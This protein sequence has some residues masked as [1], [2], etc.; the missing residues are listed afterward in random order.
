MRRT[1]VVGAVVSIF[2]LITPTILSTQ[3]NTFEKISGDT[4]NLISKDSGERWFGLLAINF[5]SAEGIP[6][7]Y[8]HG[9]LTNVDATFSEKTML[10]SAHILFPVITRSVLV[11]TSNDLNV[12]IDFFYGRIVYHG[13]MG[14]LLGFSLGISWMEV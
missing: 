1:I 2:L 5:S 9:T 13:N 12:K 4:N 14:M 3:T 8:F 7:E 6:T 10:I 11:E